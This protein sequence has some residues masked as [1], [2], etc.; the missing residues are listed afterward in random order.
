MYA[1]TSIR[2]SAFRWNPDRTCAAYGLAL[3]QCRYSRTCCHRGFRLP[4]GGNARGVWRCLIVFVDRIDAGRFEDTNRIF[5]PPARFDV[6][7]TRE[8]APEE[9]AARIVGILAP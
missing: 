3:Q 7:I 4:D 2:T 5:T 9:W 8:G 1:P 6:R